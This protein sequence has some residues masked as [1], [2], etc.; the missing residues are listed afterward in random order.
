MSVNESMSSQ[1][2]RSDDQGH[3]LLA[4]LGCVMSQLVDQAVGP[5]EHSST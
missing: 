4:G 1:L 5:N 2:L 3:V